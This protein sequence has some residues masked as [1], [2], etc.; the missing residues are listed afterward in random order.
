MKK[1]LYSL[2]I[3]KY[4]L[5]CSK[6]LKEKRDYFLPEASLKSGNPQ[7]SELKNGKMIWEE[8]IKALHY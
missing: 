1:N 7:T 8:Q 4:L 3:S 5:R 6:K 2:D